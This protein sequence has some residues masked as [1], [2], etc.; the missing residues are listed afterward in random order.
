MRTTIVALAAAFVFFKSLAAPAFAQKSNAPAEFFIHEDD[1]MNLPNFKVPLVIS[2][3]GF[4]DDFGPGSISYTGPMPPRPNDPVDL[5]RWRRETRNV[6]RCG[7]I[8]AAAGTTVTFSVRAVG[9]G[10]AIGALPLWL[11]SGGLG[12]GTRKIGNYFCQKILN[13]SI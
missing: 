9:T 8:S 3:N 10:T 6:H 12:A 5:E 11:I 13:P 2:E 4:G 1:L 7:L